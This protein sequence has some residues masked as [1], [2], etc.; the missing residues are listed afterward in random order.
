M[1]LSALDDYCCT[2]SRLKTELGPKALRSHS[3][4]TVTRL[5]SLVRV[6]SHALEYADT[7][8]VRANICKIMHL[9]VSIRS[10]LESVRQDPGFSGHASNLAVYDQPHQD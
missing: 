1:K 9:P 2:I 8:Q 5:R 10:V 6:L 7:S 4:G 3:P